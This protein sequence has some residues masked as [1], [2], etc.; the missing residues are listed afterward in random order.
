MLVRAEPSEER[1]AR[2][3]RK[4]GRVGKGESWDGG[5]KIGTKKQTLLKNM[6]SDVQNQFPTFLRKRSSPEPPLVI[7]WPLWEKRVRP[8]QL[9]CGPFSKEGTVSGK[10]VSE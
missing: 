3:G 6:F 4:G 2:R 5:M 9:G 10:I 8:K 7:V 1:R